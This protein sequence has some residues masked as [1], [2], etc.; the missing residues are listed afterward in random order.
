LVE[1]RGKVCRVCR[2]PAGRGGEIPPERRYRIDSYCKATFGMDWLE[3]LTLVQLTAGEP[4]LLSYVIAQ[5]PAYS[6]TSPEVLR[7]A[8]ET[9]RW[10]ARPD[11]KLRRAMIRQGSLP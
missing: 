3:F 10:F 4:R 8:W 1:L 9:L 11:L 5:Q 7:A 6:S 2:T